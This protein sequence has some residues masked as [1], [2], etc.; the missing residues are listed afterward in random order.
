MHIDIEEVT[1][2]E[3]LKL[4]PAFKEAGLKLKNFKRTVWIGAKHGNKL[5]GVCA[6]RRTRYGV[7]C[8]SDLVLEPYRRR[9]IYDLL[10]Q[11]RL[12]R[13]TGIPTDKVYAYCNRNSLPVYL[14]YGFVRKGRLRKYTYVETLI[15]DL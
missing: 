2:S 7:K 1:F 11:E 6:F 12:K 5:V 8:R 10:F 13:I 3:V 15:P 14:K 9:G 4:K